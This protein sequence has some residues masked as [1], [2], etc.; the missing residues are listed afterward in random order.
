MPLAAAGAPATEAAPKA[1]SKKSEVSWC[2]MC[3][4]TALQ[5]D[6]VKILRAGMEEIGCATPESFVKCAPCAPNEGIAGAFV[7]DDP[8]GDPHVILCEDNVEKFK[9]GKAHIHRTVAHE[10]VHAYDQCRAHVDWTSCF[11]VACS[12]VR[13]ANLSGDCDLATEFNRGKFSV[14]G[15]GE[16]CVR[17]RAELSVAAHPKCKDIAKEAVEKVFDSC[18]LDRAPFIGKFY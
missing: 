10:L 18:L 5:Q 8:D 14:K 17:R 2:E 6:K 13:A 16:R 11:H 15:Q 7:S 3:R 12:E 4:R 1:K 9:M